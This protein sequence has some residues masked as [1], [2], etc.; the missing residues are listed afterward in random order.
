[1]K[2]FVLVSIID[3][4]CYGVF[5]DE[6]KAYDIGNNLHRPAEWEVYEREVK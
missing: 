4:Y 5:A 6:T 3:G 2:V 1:M